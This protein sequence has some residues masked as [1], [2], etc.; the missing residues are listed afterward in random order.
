MLSRG[1]SWASE[2]SLP[3]VSIF[4]SQNPGHIWF[5]WWHFLPSILHCPGLKIAIKFCGAMG[6][7]LQ[8]FSS[9]DVTAGRLVRQAGTGYRH[10]ISHIFVQIT[11]TSHGNPGWPFWPRC[12]QKKLKIWKKLCVTNS[13]WGIM[14]DPLIALQDNILTET[15][16]FNGV[17]HWIKN[18]CH[19]F[20]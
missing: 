5:F 20:A 13:R 16:I 1:L 4:R 17:I 15:S 6:Q 3:W 2:I 7:Y 14:T 19:K 10:G 12:A 11:R 8:F 9:C 18:E